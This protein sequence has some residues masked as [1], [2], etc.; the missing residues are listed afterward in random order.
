MSS[1]NRLGMIVSCLFPSS[2]V[3]DLMVVVE[4][5]S[6]DPHGSD[7]DLGLVPLGR[8][9]LVKSSSLTLTTGPAH[10]L[11]FRPGDSNHLYIGT[12]M[13]SHVCKIHCMHVCTCTLLILFELCLV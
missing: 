2:G 12:D 6:P 5:L 10:C 1:T 13:V 3:L 9:K 11:Q 7:S 8:V 4:V